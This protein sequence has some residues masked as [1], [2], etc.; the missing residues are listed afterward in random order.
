MQMR[1]LECSLAALVFALAGA[2]KPACA[3]EDYTVDRMHAG[4]TFKI[5]H[6]GFAWI[7]GRFNDFSGNFTLDPDD[8]GKCAFSMMIKT[9]SVDTNNSQ[10]DNHLRS[11][12]FFN[13]KQFPAIT[14]RSTAVTPIK[15]GYKV[16]GELTMHGVTKPVTFELVGGRR[17]QFPPRVERTGFTAEFPI[18]RSDFGV[19]ANK[20][21]Q[22]LGDE[23]RAT[24]SFEGTKRK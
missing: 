17:G 18:K 14:F 7:Q 4:V 13:A 20:F 22:V 19:G 16:T 3:A 23:V 8:P 5:L 24:V 9:E 11:P 12:D 6:G 21:D 1:F 2:A 10:R 15:D